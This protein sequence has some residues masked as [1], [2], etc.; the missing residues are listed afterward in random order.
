MR[1]RDDVTLWT[2]DET[3]RATLMWVSVEV[4]VGVRVMLCHQSYA[5]HFFVNCPL[6]VPILILLSDCIKSSSLFPVAILCTLLH[7][8]NTSFE[9]WYLHLHC[10]LAHGFAELVVVQCGMPWFSTPAS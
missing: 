7:R 10:G 8:E 5:I 4:V 1:V 9:V 3:M 6:L 2:R